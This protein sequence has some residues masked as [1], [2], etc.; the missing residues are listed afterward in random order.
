MR[1]RCLNP[2]DRA[3]IN[4]GARGISV[5]D[6]WIEDFEMFY[7]DMGVRPKGKSLDRIDNDQGYF[8]GNCRWATHT[9]QARNRRSNRVVR[10]FDKEKTIAE[11]SELLGLSR[12]RIEV[13]ARSSG[14]LEAIAA[15]ALEEKASPPAGNV[16]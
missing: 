16:D 3:Y 2:S 12:H 13:A 15:F 5:C 4:Y 1:R 8:P 14:G 10:A 11:W 6:E 7:K 9:E